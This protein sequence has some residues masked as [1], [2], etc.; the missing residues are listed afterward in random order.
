[1]LWGTE[2]SGERIKWFGVI[3]T[4]LVRW[5][6]NS[7]L[8]M[9]ERFK[10]TLRSNNHSLSFTI[11]RTMVFIITRFRLLSELVLLLYLNRSCRNCLNCASQLERWDL[12]QSELHAPKGRVVVP[13]C[14]A[15]R[16]RRFFLLK[17]V[18]EVCDCL[19]QNTW[20]T[21]GEHA[22]LFS[23]STKESMAKSFYFL[24]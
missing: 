16:L 3:E 21:H 23:F 24:S 13:F 18:I 4:S 5:F 14:A 15:S 9:V 11:D 2:I 1:M 7:E 10:L 8:P 17:H 12:E 20:Y 22:N 19:A 6:P